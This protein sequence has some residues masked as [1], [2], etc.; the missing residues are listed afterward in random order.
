MEVVRSKIMERPPR[1]R[2]INPATG[3]LLGEFP[4]TP[5]EEVEKVV[6]RAKQTQVMWSSLSFRERAEWILKFKEFVR[7]NIEDI[8]DVIAKE[9]GVSRFEALISDVF[10]I[11]DLADFYAKNTEKILAREKVKIGVWNIMGRESYLEY[12]PYGVIGIISPWNFP[13]S[14]PVGQIIIAL[15]AGNTCVLKPSEFTP[16]VGVMIGELFREIGMPQGVV[17]VVTGDGITGEALVRCK[18][19]G[20]IFFTGSTATGI[21]I[22][23]AAAENLTPVVMELGGK[24]PMI[25]FEDADLDIASDGAV[26]GAFFNTGQVCASV[27][28]L[29]VQKSVFDEFVELVAEKTKKLRVGASHLPWEKDMGSVISEKQVEKIKEHIEDAMEKGAEIKVGGRI[30]KL[31][32]EPTVIVNVDKKFKVVN[33]ETFGPVLPAM[34]FET[35]DEAVKLAND[36][37]YGLT[38]SVWTKDIKKAERVASKL[39]YATVMINDNLITHAIPQV[40]WGGV[41][42][43][44]IGRTHGKEG[45][46][47]MVEIRHVH[48][49]KMGMKMRS[50][51]WYP[52]T[53]EKYEFA[54]SLTNLLHSPSPVEKLK[55]F[56][57]VIK[58]I[59]KISK[60][61]L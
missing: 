12:F 60:Q 36:S 56:V 19:V 38:A 34:R 53:E 9:K 33:E 32:V 15:M 20:K 3:E 28:R 4:N 23:K 49:N 48:K 30:E 16:K 21:K 50:P 14:I 11:L 2:S 46:L 39:E 17:E 5:P 25:V 29:Y 57:G 27:E 59:G 47:E 13:F 10:P 55:G 52:F 26:F 24:D 61:K 22:M 51:W 37:E 18:D 41:K 45:L 6:K 58:N 40:P 7:K 54:L 1:L 35:E 8:S 44:G 43:S 31:F 42:K